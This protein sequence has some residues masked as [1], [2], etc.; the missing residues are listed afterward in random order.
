LG[1]WTWTGAFVSNL[2]NQGNGN[3]ASGK[4]MRK[5]SAGKTNFKKSA[6]DKGGALIDG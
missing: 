3:S 4:S 6:F 1:K 5:S 2:F